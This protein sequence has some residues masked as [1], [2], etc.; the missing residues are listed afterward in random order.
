M[1]EKP[2]PGFHPGIYK[3]DVLKLK[4]EDPLLHY[5]KSGSPK[6]RWSKNV[7]LPSYKEDKNLVK[8]KNIKIAIHIHVYYLDLLDEILK[9]ISINET[10]PDLLITT[11][12]QK[13]LAK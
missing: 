5:L 12:F 11:P 6:G 4:N 13:M 7:I 10:K 3:E 9:A 2:F 8:S 1:L